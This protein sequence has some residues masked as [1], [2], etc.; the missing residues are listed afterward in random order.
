METDFLFKEKK[1]ANHRNDSLFLL[2]K[3]DML[4]GHSF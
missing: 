2:A 4:E 1:K 3:C